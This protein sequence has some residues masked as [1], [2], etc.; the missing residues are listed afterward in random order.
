[1]TA[2][3]PRVWLRRNLFRSPVDGAITIV[4]AVVAV[5]VAYRSLNFVFVT[6][7]WDIIRANLRLLMYGRFPEPHV[8]RL[9]VAIVVLAAWAGLIAGIVHGRRRRNA[10]EPA[11]VPARTRLLDLAERFW[12]PAAVVVLLLL[13]TS[14]AGPWITV[15]LAVV[16][17]VV[18]RLVGP[19]IGRWRLGARAGPHSQPRSPRCPWRCTSTSSSQWGSTSGAG[20]C[21]TSSSRCARSCCATRWASCSRSG[22]VRRCR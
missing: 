4:A 2:P 20:S 12:I 3:T 6:G 22:A 14:T 16:A 11:S 10:A 15:A 1:M 7:R 13:L 5:Y 9:A 21:S 19:I 18:G 17:G 8:L